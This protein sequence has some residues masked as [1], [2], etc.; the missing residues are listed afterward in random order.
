MAHSINGS[1]VDPVNA[2]LQRA[3]NR[4]DGRLVV[5][6]APTKLPTRPTDCPGTKA[7]WRDGQIG[8]TEALRFHVRL[9]DKFRFRVFCSHRLNL[10]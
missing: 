9:R 6:L 10:S 5:L 3:M 4:G 1:R 8:V 7:N 2:K